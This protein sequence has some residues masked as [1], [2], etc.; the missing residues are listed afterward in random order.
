M[1]GAHVFR[2]AVPVRKLSRKLLSCC[3]HCFA[4]FAYEKEASNVCEVPLIRNVIAF[5]PLALLEIRGV[6]LGWIEQEPERM[7][8]SSLNAFR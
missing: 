3:C 5:S 7:S 4:S 1:G 6:R 2:A 8:Q